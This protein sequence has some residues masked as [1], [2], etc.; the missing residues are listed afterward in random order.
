MSQELIK[1][2]E[3][4]IEEW[5][6][7]AFDNAAE[8]TAIFISIKQEIN[9]TEY[10]VELCY[11]LK[12]ETGNQLFDDL[13]E[14]NAINKSKISKISGYVNLATKLNNVVDLAQ[15]VTD[16][17]GL[18]QKYISD[19]EV[20]VAEAMSKSLST[21]NSTLE[22]IS[23]SDWVSSM[24]SVAIDLLD[25]GTELVL[26]RVELYNQLD[27]VLESVMNGTSSDAEETQVK[28]MYS[29]VKAFEESCCRDAIR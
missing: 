22:I 25:K 6:D 16:I 8:I 10:Q 11:K 4:M 3:S 7:K 19:G 20:S 15:N 2:L 29:T 5:G 13:L 1:D 28:D 9:L 12:S 21:L 26:Q 23:C 14:A 17:F 27:A 24:L 18:V